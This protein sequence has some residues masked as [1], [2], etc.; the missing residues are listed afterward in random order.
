MNIL[1]LEDE[2][3]V[4]KNLEKLIRQLLPQATLHGPLVSIEAAS[5]WFSQYDEPDLIM[6]DIQLADGVSFDI[7]QELKLSCPIIFTTA[8]DVLI[9]C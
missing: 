3:L 8:Y 7:F 1:L 6:A 2:P 5:N 9:I 4:A